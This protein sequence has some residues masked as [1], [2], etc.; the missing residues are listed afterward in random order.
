MKKASQ[1]SS[2][3]SSNRGR[4]R[5]SITTNQKKSLTTS[6]KSTS[7][8][9]EPLHHTE[10]EEEEP[11]TSCMYCHSPVDDELTI[12]C[13]GPNCQHEAHLYCLNPP[14]LIV[15]EEEWFCEFCDPKGSTSL[16]EKY[17]HSHQEIFNSFQINNRESYDEYLH[18]LRYMTTSIEDIEFDKPEHYYEPE[19]NSTSLQLIGAH[20]ILLNTFDDRWHHGRI[21][22]VKSLEVPFNRTLHLIQFKR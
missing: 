22:D 11:S 16:L 5:T 12:L 15:P 9:Q 14:L 17:L 8:S 10:D 13:D 20:I 2:S 19:F 18:V 3:S 7:K 21:I 6:I 4:K 1:T